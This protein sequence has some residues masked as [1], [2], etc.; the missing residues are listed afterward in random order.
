MVGRRRRQMSVLLLTASVAIAACHSDPVDP[1]D[2]AAA[3]DGPAVDIDALVG[4]R[5]T[6]PALPEMADPIIAGRCGDPHDVFP[7]AKLGSVAVAVS[8]ARSKGSR[9]AGVYGEGVARVAVL[10]YCDD[11]AARFAL[12]RISTGSLRECVT[13]AIEH[14]RSVHE[15]ANTDAPP[16]VPGP[17]FRIDGTRTTVDG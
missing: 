11:R 15:I 12:E 16:V 3:V 6:A 9:S 14:Y 13:H 8:D 1:A 2:P 17:L 10:A 7:E 5:W 4:G